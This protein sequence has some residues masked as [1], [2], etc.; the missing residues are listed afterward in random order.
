MKTNTTPEVVASRKT[1]DG[2]QVFL[3]ADGSIS[4][5]M[6]F[7]RGRLP[8]DQMWRVIDDFCLYD[9]AELPQL[10]RDVRAGAWKPFAIRDWVKAEDRVYRSYGKLAN[11]LDL[12]V[13]VR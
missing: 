6:Y 3:H 10:L 11:G 4:C 7:L 1:F 9:W 12:C 8:V 5:V 2:V 13:R